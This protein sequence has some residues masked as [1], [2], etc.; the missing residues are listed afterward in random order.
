MQ[1]AALEALIYSIDNPILTLVIAF[2]AGFLASRI[3]AAD[4]RPGVI[5]FTIIGLIGFFLSHFVLSY[6]QLSETLES[7]HELRVFID[8]VAAF[9]GSFVIAGII[10]FLKPS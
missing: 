8:L 6:Y 7:L 9:F 10:H 1:E 3:V 2:L 4:R 5:G